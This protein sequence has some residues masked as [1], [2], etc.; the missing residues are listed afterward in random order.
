VS[1][2]SSIRSEYETE[3]LRL[4][5]ALMIVNE[6]IV[7]LSPLESRFLWSRFQE[8]HWWVNRGRTRG[9]ILKSSWWISHVILVVTNQ[10]AWFGFCVQMRDPQNGNEETS[11]LYLYIN[12]LLFMFSLSES[13]IFTVHVS[14]MV[15]FPWITI[16]LIIL[17]IRIRKWN[18]TLL[19]II[20]NYF[21]ILLLLVFYFA[22]DI[23][24]HH[25]ALSKFPWTN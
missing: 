23:H 4:L 2:I 16:Y 24:F 10:P 5:T 6:K 11:S 22:S 7:K 15:S 17:L 25:L 3:T 20:S 14:I 21:C 13:Y 8:I 1:L 19:M 18:F 12:A 9:Q